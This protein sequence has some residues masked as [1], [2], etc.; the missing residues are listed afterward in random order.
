[1]DKHA[2]SL[3]NLSIL[4]AEAGQRERR[5]GTLAESTALRE[6]LIAVT[7][8]DDPRRERFLS[9]LGSCY[10]NLGTGHLEDG[11]LDEAVAWTRKAL[12]IQDEQIKKRP[13]SVDYLERVGANHTVLGQLEYRT[14]HL[15]TART[16]VELARAYLERL[17][18]VQPGDVAY[19]MHLVE[20]LGLL[21]DVEIWSGE[22]TPALGLARR[23]VS[24]AEGMLRIN[25]KYHPA[26]QGLA[27][28]LLRDAEIS[29]DIGE[30]DRALAN[31]DRAEAILRRLVASY[32][33]LTNYRCDLATTLRVHVRMDSEIGRDRD[34]EP[35]LR[36]AMALTES[37]LR[38]DP[39]LVMNLPYTAALYSDLANT[40]GRRD[41]PAEARILY[42]RALDRLDQARKRSPRDARIRRMLARTLAARAEF[43]G[44][45]GQLR[46][47]LDDWNRAMALAA[48]TDVLE[49]R[50]GRATSL[51]RSSDYR[52]AVAD[53]MAADRSID[54][55]A[56]LRIGSAL[57]HAALSEAIRRD[58]SLTRDVRAECV[59][60]QLTAAFEQIGQSK[61]SPAYRDPRRL[62]H[63]LSDHDF[64]PLREQRS[65]QLLMLDL[66]FPVQP[67]AHGTTTV[68]MPGLGSRPPSSN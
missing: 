2:A 7:P 51:A 41:Q 4:F 5:M 46:E 24:E 3:N 35:R 14:G 55:R 39:D 56:N 62:Y 54:D 37:A 58:R 47:S 53:V 8:A 60:S 48:D 18:H 34:D 59:A 32:P 44:R 63:R 31:L 9:N 22:T 12:A 43:L 49:F 65:F 27:D 20:C 21:A 52:S 61:R 36:E 15:A 30:S 38:D 11:A 68:P 13:N 10:G 64:D 16:E 57:S 66:A 17:V 1:M 29:W 67:F 19:R 33:E 42:A 50:L 45:F 23:A 40:I 6:R 26:S 25:P 28:Q